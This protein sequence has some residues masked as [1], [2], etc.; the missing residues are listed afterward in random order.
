MGTSLATV[1]PGRD[2]CGR[3][4]SLA[5]VAARSAAV[6]RS[7]KSIR[8]DAGGSHDPGHTG[9]VLVQEPTLLHHR[10][11]PATR[12]EEP[13]KIKSL[14]WKGLHTSPSGNIKIRQHQVNLGLQ[15]YL[16]SRGLDL[17]NPPQTPSQTSQKVLGSQTGK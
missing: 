7:A 14:P 11:M 1:K 13:G 2:R 3:R 12:V 4:T 5:A 15:S 9:T 6:P 17:P 8:E 10:L 16:L